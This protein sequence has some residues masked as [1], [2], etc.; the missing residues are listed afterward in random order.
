M[1]ARN[2]KAVSVA[3]ILILVIG[4]S[5]AVYAGAQTRHEKYQAL[6]VEFEREMARMYQMSPEESIA[7]GLKVKRLGWEIGQLE[8]ELYPNPAKDLERKIFAMK[9]AYGDMA[10]WYRSKA[11]NDPEAAKVLERV[12]IKQE[13]LQQ[14]EKAFKEQTRPVEELLVELDNLAKSQ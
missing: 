14:I 6:K 1:A 13:K 2:W 8:N 9:A 5:L 7:Q 12:I 11:K 3:A 4:A 10:G